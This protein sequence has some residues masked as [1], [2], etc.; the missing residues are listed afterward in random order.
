VGTE[1]SL[2][3]GTANLADDLAAAE[4][5]TMFEQWPGGHDRPY[6]RSHIADYLV[7]YTT[8]WVERAA[9]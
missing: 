2:K 4:V 8:P 5:P 7:F 6:W 9:Y 3:G 1:D